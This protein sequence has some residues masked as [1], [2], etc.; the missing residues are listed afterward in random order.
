[1]SPHCWVHV[2]NVARVTA[3]PGSGRAAEYYQCFLWR[4]C[5][6][7]DQHRWNPG[8]LSVFWQFFSFA[9]AGEQ[10]W[11]RLIKGGRFLF[12]SLPVAHPPTPCSLS[13]P[14]AGIPA[15]CASA[16]HTT[17]FG[18]E[19][20]RALCRRARGRTLTNPLCPAWEW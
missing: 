17:G 6:Q 18:M 2:G 8:D 1:M 12:V 11:P 14:P 20:L 19:R 5:V 13:H 16:C 15:S 4:T 9:R 3:R 7:A 10:L